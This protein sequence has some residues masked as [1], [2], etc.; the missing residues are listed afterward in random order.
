MKF[1][2]GQ[3]FTQIY[4]KLDIL[5]ESR[6]TITINIKSALERSLRAKC[7]QAVRTDEEVFILRERATML[8]YMYTAYLA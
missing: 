2:I 8:R 3:D 7:C 6:F 5:H 1:D 4:T